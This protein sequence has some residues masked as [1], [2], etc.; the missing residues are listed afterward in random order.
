MHLVQRCTSAACN[1]IR[2]QFSKRC[3]TMLT[4]YADGIAVFIIIII[5]ITIIIFIII[6]RLL[7]TVVLFLIR[8]RYISRDIVLNIL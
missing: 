1:V 5:I 4:L 7:R 8:K 2:Y 3:Y 6:L